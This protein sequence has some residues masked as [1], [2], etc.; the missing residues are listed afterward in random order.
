MIG[1]T[2]ESTLPEVV[3]AEKASQTARQTRKLQS[4]PRVRAV[5]KSKEPLVVAA[6]IV[7]ALRVAS[8]LKRLASVA[9]PA[10]KTEPRKLPK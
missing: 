2:I 7:A 5:R 4:T 3:V 8:V 9:A 1:K 10:I 6:A